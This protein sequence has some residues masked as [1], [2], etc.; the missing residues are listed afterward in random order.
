[1]PFFINFNGSYIPTRTF[2]ARAT[3]AEIGGSCKE[4][5]VEGCK[6]QIVAIYTYLKYHIDNGDSSFSTGDIAY[7]TSEP[8]SLIYDAVDDVYGQYLDY[9]GNAAFTPFSSSCA[10]KS[11]SATGTWG[12]KSYPYLAGGVSSPEEVCI[13]SIT[14]TSDKLKEYVSDYNSSLT[15]SSLRINLSGDPSTWLKIISH[16]GAYNGSVG[17]ITKI[18]VGD[19]EIRGNTFRRMIGY[20][21]LRSH[22]FT[23][24]YN[25]S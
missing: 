22:C 20:S 15:D 6:A 4:A 11:S 23:M 14:V 24:T 21:T 8:S 13:K 19:K 9:N 12:G 25:A 5:T 7:K 17:Y 18:R 10:G 1:L 16:D 3:N 2:L